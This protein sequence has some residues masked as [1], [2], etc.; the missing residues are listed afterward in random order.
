MKLTG[1]FLSKGPALR[2]NIT[3]ARLE[4]RKNMAKRRKDSWKHCILMAISN[5]KKITRKWLKVVNLVRE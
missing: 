2:K 4:Y 1:H 5:I 3:E